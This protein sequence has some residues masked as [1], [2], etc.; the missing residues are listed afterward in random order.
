[1]NTAAKK[2]RI[3]S[4]APYYAAAGIWIVYLILYRIYRLTD[5][6]L[7]ALVATLGFIIS[8]LF[9]DGEKLNILFSPDKPAGRWVEIL[10]FLQKKKNAQAILILSVL[11]S[12]LIAFLLH[13]ATMPKVSVGT[14]ICDQEDLLSDDAETTITILNDQWNEQHNAVCTVATVSSTAGWDLA[15]YTTSLGNKWGLGPNDMTLVI[16][17]G[18]AASD[19]PYWHIAYGDTLITEM[20]DAQREQIHTAFESGYAAD[21]YDGAVRGVFFACAEI[22]RTLPFDTTD[23]YMMFLYNFYTDS[24]WTD[25]SSITISSVLLVIW[26]V[27]VI[28]AVLDRIRYQHYLRVKAQFPGIRLPYY[29]AM[30]WGRNPYA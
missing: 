8:A 3:R 2:E 21:G 28:W 9:C 16:D 11:L 7:L 15:E 25:H 14:W 26:I 12:G 17:T 27:F 29:H 6:L 10:E 4:V 19:T 23:F 1:M 30:F 22:F 18:A 20:S 5:L 24:G 13:P